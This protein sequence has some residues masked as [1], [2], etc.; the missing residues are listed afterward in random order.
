MVDWSR[1]TSFAPP[2]QR[3]VPTAVSGSH[4]FASL[5]AGGFH[6]CGTP[7]DGVAYCWGS[8]N[9]GRL[10]DGTEIDRLVP[11]AVSGSHVFASL[12]AGGYHNCGTRT[13]GAA[14]CWGD[15]TYGMLGD[16]TTMNRNVPTPVSGWTA[17]P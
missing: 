13:D 8:N 14:Y 2:C 6:T 17:L 7:S 4:S 15:N 16:G 1:A 5:S 11:T 12:N 10:G 3:N 9:A